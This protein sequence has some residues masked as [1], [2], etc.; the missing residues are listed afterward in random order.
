M[1]IKRYN[2]FINEEGM[3]MATA[4]N[5]GGMGAVVTPQPSSTPGDVAGS[6]KGSGDLPAGSST[7][8]VSKDEKKKKKDKPKSKRKSK[9]SKKES[10]ESEDKSTMYISKYTDWDYPKES[11]NEDYFLKTFENYFS[12]PNYT[13][14]DENI[15]SNIENESD[16]NT[17]FHEIKKDI[18]MIDGVVSV[19]MDNRNLSED[20]GLQ[21]CDYNIKFEG[22]EEEFYRINISYEKDIDELE[23]DIFFNA[24]HQYD[25]YNTIFDKFISNNEYNELIDYINEKLFD[26]ETTRKLD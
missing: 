12:E 5:T 16:F 10:Y 13:W 18:N 21:M 24:I 19:D 26:A 6:I 9:K 15:K 25:L 11:M 20:T 1:K 8:Q 14:G 23:C 7:H 4:G 2:D 17:Q 3:A 22:M